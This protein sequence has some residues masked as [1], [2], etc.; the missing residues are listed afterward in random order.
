MISA[1]RRTISLLSARGGYA[2]GGYAYGE[3]S[4]LPFGG[5]ISRSSRGQK[6]TIRS[7][8]SVR[9]IVAYT[10]YVT[11]RNSMW[12]SIVG[13]FNA[14]SYT[15]LGLTTIIERS[16]AARK[17]R[18]LGSRARKSRA[19]PMRRSRVSPINGR[20]SARV[21]GPSSVKSSVRALITRTR[22]FR[23]IAGARRCATRLRRFDASALTKRYVSPVARDPVGD[24]CRRG[25]I[26]TD[27]SISELRTPF[28][29]S[30]IAIDRPSVDRALSATD[31]R[32]QVY[33]C[34]LLLL[35]MFQLRGWLAQICDFARSRLI[36]ARHCQI[37][38]TD[39]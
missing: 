6:L 20:F 24:E 36:A 7:A 12:Q 37:L 32:A 8:A 4:Q 27:R 34:D 11:V 17:S 39:Y 5:A 22:N 19:V 26:A 33:F 2:R 30:K 10:R 9:D 28:E 3:R 23:Q 1:I 21:R 25:D 15:G 35:P 29:L 31:S 16:F 13:K 18:L 14:E 38:P